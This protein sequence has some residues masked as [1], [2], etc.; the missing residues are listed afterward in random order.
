MSGPDRRPAGNR[1]AKRSAVVAASEQDRPLKIGEAAELVG[2]KPYVLRFWETEFPSLRPNHTVSKHRLYTARD[3][4]ALRLIKR[5]LYEE[6]F[7]IDGA[8]RRIR[9]LGYNVR[10]EKAVPEKAMPGPDQER[11]QTPPADGARKALA[12]IRRD[13]R[14]L[15]EMLK[16]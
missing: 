3:I 6:G 12:E 1:K 4:E 9:E 2:V 11:R 14:S 10:A 7:T 15:Y 8:R 5:L 13:L 16:D